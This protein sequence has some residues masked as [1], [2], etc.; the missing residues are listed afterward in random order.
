M[1]RDG[2]AWFDPNNSNR[3]SST[4][5]DVYEQSE[6]A[7]RTEK[8]GLWQQENPVAPWEFV[9]A[10]AIRKNPAPSLKDVIADTQP[11]HSGPTSELTNLTLMR[12][13]NSVPMSSAAAE[14]DTTWVR[15]SARK[16]WTRLQPPGESFSVEV[17][18]DGERLTTPVAMGDQMI[19][20]KRYR[21]RDGWAVYSVSWFKGPFLGESDDIVFKSMLKEFMAGAAES[22]KYDNRRSDFNC[23]SPS[24][25]SLSQNGY[26]GIEYDLTPCRVPWRV[27]MYTKVVD[28]ERQV[29]LGAAAFA[30]EDAE[31]VTRF[32]KSITVGAAKTRTR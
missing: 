24:G 3:L 4:N 10:E 5:R 16:N 2:A 19:D 26:T 25:K 23:Q 18:E 30:E 14:N 6:L 12:G 7:A 22:F 29:Y 32:L 13:T 11:K 15:S 9:K 17:P 28:S 1:I 27:R 21:V 31:N 8:R 20:V